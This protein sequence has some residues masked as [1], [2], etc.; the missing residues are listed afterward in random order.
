MAVR[1][2]ATLRFACKAAYLLGLTFLVAGCGGTTSPQ[3]PSTNPP[4]AAKLTGRLRGGQQPVQNAAVQLFAVGST[5][6]EAG[7]VALTSAAYTDASGDFSIPSDFTR[8]SSGTLTY[9]FAKGGNPGTG[10][11]NPAIALM[12]ALGSCGD[13]S[14]ISFVTINELTT[15]SSVWALAH[16][17]SPGAQIGTSSTNS[18]GR[19]NA[20]ANVNN[21]VN[22]V[23]GTT[24]GAGAPQGAVIP[25]SKMDTLADILATCVNT[26][27]CNALFTAATPVNG[28]APTNTLDAALNIARN[29]AANV[30]ALFAIPIPSAPF[31]PTLNASP[32]D[33]TL[34]VSYSGGGRNASGALALDASGNVWTA[35]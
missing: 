14:S 28:T 27:A 8:P 29:P 6:Y 1:R 18:L 16:F 5:G 4:A 11:D 3:G 7:A 9:L 15:V 21:L 31:Q 35:N 24:P 30:A 19:E 23:T 25:I 22:S 12:A 2:E 32:A 10:T 26:G 33:W 13:L 17:L 20:F 34:A